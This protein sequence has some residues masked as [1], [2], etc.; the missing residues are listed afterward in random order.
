MKLSME[1]HNN[2]LEYMVQRDGWDVVSLSGY[3]EVSE[4]FDYPMQ[5]IRLEENYDRVHMKKHNFLN[6]SIHN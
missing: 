2:Y 4:L 6:K 3:R 5:K 1:Y